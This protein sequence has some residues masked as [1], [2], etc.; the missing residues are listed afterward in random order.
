MRPRDPRKE[1]IAA[2]MVA[3]LIMAILVSAMVW[4]N[5]FGLGA[6]RLP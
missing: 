1:E 6:G 4:G 5:C 3:G 2:T